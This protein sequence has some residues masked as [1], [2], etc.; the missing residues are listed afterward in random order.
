MCQVYGPAITVGCSKCGDGYYENE[1][2]TCKV[3]VPF[4]QWNA[5][6]QTRAAEE[7][8]GANRFLITCRRAT[9]N[10]AKWPE[11]KRRAVWSEEFRYSVKGHQ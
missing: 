6:L 1:P 4:E 7:Y 5:E 9:K 10:V 2:H 8:T 11:W 3:F